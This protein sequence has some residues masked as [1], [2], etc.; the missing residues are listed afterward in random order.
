MTPN[1][2]GPPPN[3][4]PYITNDIDSSCY[5]EFTVSTSGILYGRAVSFRE[6]NFYCA[7]IRD[8]IELKPL[9][10]VLSVIEP[11]HGI[12]LI[13]STFLPVYTG[14]EVT[15]LSPSWAD[16]RRE[17]LFD[18]FEKHEIALLQPSV[19]KG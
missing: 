13:L 17:T 1:L 12:G 18:Q 3:L 16:N 10:C 9:T 19:I 5:M 11:Y 8:H 15:F 4:D 6:I 14:S 2:K 7:Q